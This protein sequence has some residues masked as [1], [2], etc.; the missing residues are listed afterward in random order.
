MNMTGRLSRETGLKRCVV[1]PI[2]VHSSP[3]LSV[4]LVMLYRHHN[5]N[6]ILMRFMSFSCRVMLQLLK[7]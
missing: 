1:S 2:S 4:S 3:V 6:D 7:Q 5:R